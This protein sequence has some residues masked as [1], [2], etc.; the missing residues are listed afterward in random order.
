MSSS[1]HPEGSTEPTRTTATG[2]I[3]LVSFIDAGKHV[4]RSERVIRNWLAEGKLHGYRVGP[5]RQV[6]VDLDE[7]EAVAQ[8]LPHR[9]GGA[10]IIQLPARPEVVRAEVVQP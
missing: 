3:R 5:A 4:D 1:T 2:P 9:Y 6:L 10:A 8:R 7:V